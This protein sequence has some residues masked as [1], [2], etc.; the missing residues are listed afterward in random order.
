MIAYF[1]PHTLLELVKLEPEEY[2]WLLREA[3]KGNA[4][5]TVLGRTPTA[6]QEVLKPLWTQGADLWEQS[7]QALRDEHLQPEV[8]LWENVFLGWAQV[9]L[10][11]IRTV[12]NRRD[13]GWANLLKSFTVG[14]H[15][16]FP[17][18][19]DYPF[20]HGRDRLLQLAEILEVQ[21]LPHDLPGGEIPEAHKAFTRL[22]F[23][24]LLDM[25]LDPDRDLLLGRIGRAAG[26]IDRALQHVK[27]EDLI[28]ARKI[29][30]GIA[31]VKG[32]SVGSAQKPKDVMD[33]RSFRVACSKRFAERQALGEMITP[34]TI[35]AKLEC[36][37]DWL[38]DLVDGR[39]DADLDDAELRIW[40]FLVGLQI[41]VPA[42]RFLTARPTPIG[43]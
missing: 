7:S 20:Q 9:R 11:G 35:A 22:G 30:G 18:S 38:R 41:G 37:E 43:S 32:L 23:G 26:L 3:R 33:W 10:R 29:L 36:D 14:F 40:A 28:Q 31:D 15:P 5:T 12:M 27:S 4:W 42:G 16:S 2:A 17:G 39:L 1:D 34:S 21:P 6:I 8:P 13:S 25:L 24:M 19:V